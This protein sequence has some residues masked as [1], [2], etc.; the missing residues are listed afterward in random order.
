MTFAA[1]RKQVTVGLNVDLSGIPLCGTDIGRLALAGNSRLNSILFRMLR[2]LDSA[3]AR[4]AN[5]GSNRRAM[6][7]AAGPCHGGYGP[8]IASRGNDLRDLLPSLAAA[9]PH[10][11][12]ASRTA[13]G[14][15]YGPP[16]SAR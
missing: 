14:R 13:P 11:S 5:G 4:I 7:P 10:E 15:F 3:N 12:P 9:L 8:S 2:G 6:L 1:P 16:P